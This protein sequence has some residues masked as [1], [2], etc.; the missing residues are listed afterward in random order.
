MDWIEL[1]PEEVLLL[2]SRDPEET[3]KLLAR[4]RAKAEG[5]QRVQLSDAAGRVLDG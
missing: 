1:G 4:M 2:I 3:R 5:R